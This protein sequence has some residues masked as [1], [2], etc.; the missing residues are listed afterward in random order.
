MY[1]ESSTEHL[2]SFHFIP[3]IFSWGD[4]EGDDEKE[5]EKSFRRKIVFSRAKLL[6]K[7]FYY[8]FSSF[9]FFC[10]KK[11]I[12]VWEIENV[13]FLFPLYKNN[14]PCFSFLSFFSLF[15]FFSFFA[16]KLD[17]EILPT[18]CSCVL[19]TTLLSPSSRTF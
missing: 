3:L 7:N 9:L 10:K 8:F 15:S 1:E 2:I 5:E 12:L 11:I 4:W 17:V 13:L 18:L 6:V 14:F 19:Y 16:W